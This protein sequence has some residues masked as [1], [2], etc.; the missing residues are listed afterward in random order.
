MSLPFK[1]DPSLFSPF[2]FQRISFLR[3]QDRLFPVIRIFR[4]VNICIRERGGIGHT[5][6]RITVAHTVAGE[7][8]GTEEPIS[9]KW[10][11]TNGN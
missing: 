3:G 1:K 5:M 6:R 10:L 11:P 8:N 4:N 7:S 9:E 2:K